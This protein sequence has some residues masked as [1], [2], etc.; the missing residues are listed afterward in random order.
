M[1]QKIFEGHIGINKKAYLALCKKG[2]KEAFDLLE[3]YI[4]EDKGYKN[5]ATIR[6]ILIQSIPILKL[7]LDPLW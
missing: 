7:L 2:K 1:L 5:K 6:P 3:K 4:V